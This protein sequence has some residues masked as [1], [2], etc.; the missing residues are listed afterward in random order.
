MRMNLLCEKE[1]GGAR[2]VD[3]LLRSNDLIKEVG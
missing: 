3:A 1:T 2:Q